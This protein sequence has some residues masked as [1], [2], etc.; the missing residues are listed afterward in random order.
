MTFTFYDKYIDGLEFV[1]TA[2]NEQQART[3]LAIRIEEANELGYDLPDATQW[4]LI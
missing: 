4:E 3:F 1:I 2:N